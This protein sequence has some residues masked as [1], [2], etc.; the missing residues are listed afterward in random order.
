MSHDYCFGFSGT[1]LGMTT[2]Q[3]DALR[4]Y[5]SGGSGE[6]HHGDCIGADAEAH[7]IALEYGYR[8]VL[9]P[10]TNHSKRAW[11]SARADLVRRERPY[12]GR[13][14]DIVDETITLIAVPA[15]FEEQQRGGALVHR[16]ICQ[17]ARKADRADPSGWL[18]QADSTTVRGTGLSASR[19]SQ[20][21]PLFHCPVRRLTVSPCV[22][23]L[24]S[25]GE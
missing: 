22:G 3:K 20:I 5:L 4:N 16:S 18:D 11:C 2:T 12:L 19:K 13:N 1:S 24:R 10:P 25:F 8:L 14:R 23:K 7:G 15:E 21:V 6:L 17:D 9:H